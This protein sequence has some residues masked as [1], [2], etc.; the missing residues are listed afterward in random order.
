[1]A[2]G[3]MRCTLELLLL[4]FKAQRYLLPLLLLVVLFQVVLGQTSSA[5]L[6]GHQPPLALAVQSKSSDDYSAALVEK[7]SSLPG[8]EVIEVDPALDEDAVFSRYKVQGLVILPDDFGERISQGRRVQVLY[9]SAPGITNSSLGREQV[10]DAIVQLQSQR[11]LDAALADL[12]IDYQYGEKFESIDLLDTVYEGPALQGDPSQDG[13]LDTAP[14]FGVAGLLL[15]LAYLH[16]AFVLPAPSDRRIVA[17]G[18]RAYLRQW[19]AA[20]FLVL[21]VWLFLVA[22]YF[23]LLYVLVGFAPGAALVVGFLAIVVFSTLLAAL[24]SQLFGRVVATWIFL[25]LFILNTTIG[26]GLWGQV[27]LSPAFAFI[28]PVSTVV[29]RADTT[30]L[31]V[32]VL[33]AASILVLLAT[34][35]R[36]RLRFSR[37]S[38]SGV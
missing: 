16:T 31:G 28:V 10:A 12:G 2:A 34:L 38:Y 21:L 20:L 30:L 15:L 27:T 14:V 11:A 24:L 33:V 17:L 7:L 8:I 5:V 1:M 37:H 18:R 22:L 19:T 29:A 23:L 9:L 32:E 13:P 36:I 6:G 25:P 4:S 3:G 35:I 26:G